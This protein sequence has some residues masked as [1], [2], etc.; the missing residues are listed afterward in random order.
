MRFKFLKTTCAILTMSMFMGSSVWA[1]D[2]YVTNQ[3]LSEKGNVTYTTGVT[4]EM[5]NAS[6][7]SERTYTDAKKVLMA[8]Q[9]IDEINALA[10][11]TKATFMT[12]LEQ[13]WESYDAE[14]LKNVLAEKVIPSKALYIKGSKIDN[15]SYFGNI[16]NQISETGYTGTRTVQYGICVK[17][18]EIRDWPT[19][20]IIGYDADDTD[21]EMQSSSLTVNDPF[22]VRQAVTIDGNLFYWGSSNH[23]DGWVDGEDIALCADRDEWLDAWKVKNGEKD[24]LVVT[25]DKIV[26][27]PS[28]FTTYSSE[29]KLKF[30]TILKLVAKEDIPK[31]IGERNSWNNYV[32]YLPTRNEEGQYEKKMAL[33]SEH[34]DVH[35][36]FLPMTQENLIKV[37]LNCLGNRYGW[38]GM[39]DSMDCSAYTR[40]V[41][42][43]FGFEL[44]RNTTWQQLIPGTATDLT[45]MTE[46]EKQSFIETMPAGTLLYF[47]G[48][49]MVYLGSVDHVGYVVSALGTASD[50]AGTLEILSIQSV[51]ITPLTVRRRSGNTWLMDLQ[52]AVAFAVPQ[53]EEI[54]T[55][56]TTET[57]TEQIDRQLEPSRIT[58]IKAKKKSLKIFWK[59]VKGISGYKIQISTN[60][61]FKKAKT[62]KAKKKAQTK[63]VKGLKKKKLYYVRIRTY[64]VK[65]SKNKVITYYSDW[66]KCR[67]KKTK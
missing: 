31:N 3:E 7:W 47:K 67:R 43:C 41:Y 24:F 58:K 6:F 45:G 66:S 52:S 20:D 48:H 29:V 59:K 11:K 16:K 39:L 51:A 34:C 17:S 60:K 14:A 5:S 18:T 53:P 12:D 1:E 28:I 42:R 46:A 10:L 25:Q 21:D 64:K 44:P 27:E 2:Y 26:L 38:G 36:G 19:N 23:V 33:I 13:E 4:S 55:E 37:S 15:A 35:V 57:T 30:S 61:N 49:T 40:N 63:L 62:I 22:V 50:S 32:V 54:E 65:K 56:T 8:P 9:E